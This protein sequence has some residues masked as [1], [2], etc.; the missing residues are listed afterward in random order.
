MPIYVIRKDKTQTPYRNAELIPAFLAIP[1]SILSK[2][3]PKLYHICRTPNDFRANWANIDMVES[4]YFL[5]VL[6]DAYA[7]MVWPYMGCTDYMEIY[8]GYDPA[9]LI[10]HD[11]N[12]WVPGLEEAGFLP[13]PIDILRVK[14]FEPIPFVREGV[15]DAILRDV[16]P[17]V[18][19][20]HNLYATIQTAKEYRCFEDF[21]YRDS[22]AKRGFHR[23][24]YH[25]RTKHPQISLEAYQE[26]HREAYGYVQEFPNEATPFEEHVLSQA[27]A[28]DFLHTLSET[29][30]KILT[31]RM[32]GKTLETVAKELDYQTHSAVLKRLRKIGKA[33]EKYSGEDFG[34]DD[35]KIV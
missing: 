31:M 18:M 32:D 6:M 7:Y 12:F 2:T 4:D 26:A 14:S 15:L 9:W 23:E 1:E 29:D 10:A 3:D 17:K 33:Y 19:K 27:A 20:K 13:S 34:F 30:Q 11:L 8:S 21:D 28:E 25:N 35:A 24:W 22:M 16:V 5:N